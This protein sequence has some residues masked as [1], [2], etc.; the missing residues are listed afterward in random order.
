EHFADALGKCETDEERQKLAGELIIEFGDAALLARLI[1]RGKR[2]CRSLRQKLLAGCIQAIGVIAILFSLYTAWFVTGKPVVETD[3]LA[4]LNR[5][6]RDAKGVVSDDQNARL[7]YD[8]GMEVFADFDEEESE[9]IESYAAGL[10]REPLTNDQQALVDKWLDKNQSSWGH[11][12]AGSKRPFFY[13]HAEYGSENL[14]NELSQLAYPIHYFWR[15]IRRIACWRIWRALEQGET[16]QALQDCFVMLRMA[17]QLSENSYWMV[18]HM[19]AII[20]TRESLDLMLHIVD[21]NQ[22]SPAKLKQLQKQ[23]TEFF[24]DGY[25]MIT[26]CMEEMKMSGLDYIQHNYT[27]NGSGGGHAI[28]S[29]FKKQYRYKD[30]PEVIR[31]PWCTVR[32]M[33]LATRD[34]TI[35]MLTKTDD[36]IIKDVQMTPYQFKVN[37]SSAK[38]FVSKISRLKFPDFNAPVMRRRSDMAFQM[39][40]YHE[41]AIAI[42]ALERWKLD[43]GRYPD[44]IDELVDGGYLAGLAMDPYSDGPLIYRKTNDGFTLYS[45]GT[46]F[47]DDG[48]EHGTDSE[49]KVVSWI[50]KWNIES[51]DAVFWP[52]E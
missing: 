44:R 8:K 46:D 50:N 13:H 30:W 2:R 39:K 24:P 37:G 1:R 47:D 35:A 48:G 11:F 18:E 12:V 19:I 38:E 45:V 49:G 10:S 22:L 52:I 17:R 33:A 41:A 5:M 40:A 6:H 4:L 9:V 26:L 3:Y 14:E 20:S 34:E 31:V 15:P 29:S 36:Y 25:P 7:D 51:G 23:L 16:D 42:L 43:K 28:P 32:S 21:T 27:S